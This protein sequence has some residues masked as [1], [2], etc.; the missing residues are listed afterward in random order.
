MD[1][2]KINA[3]TVGKPRIPLQDLSL[4]TKYKILG[5]QIIEGRYGECPL[6]DLGSNVVFLPNRTTRTFRDHL[7]KFSGG[8]YALVYLGKL[9]TANGHQMQQFKIEKI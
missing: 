5:I 1:L 6:V 8:D 3:V 9:R 4:N 2:D 7:E